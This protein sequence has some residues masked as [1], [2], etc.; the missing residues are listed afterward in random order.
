MGKRLCITII[1]IHEEQTVLVDTSVLVAVEFTN[2][3]AFQYTEGL[4]RSSYTKSRS[5]IKVRSLVY[6][7]RELGQLG[8]AG[9]PV[10]T[11]GPLHSSLVQH[12]ELEGE[13]DTRILRC[14]YVHENLV[15]DEWRLR[16]SI[17]V[18]QVLRAAIEELEAT[19]QAVVHSY[20]VDTDI[21]GSRL[22]P[23]QVGVRI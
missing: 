19:T 17:S 18:K 21:E 7:V 14:T 11:G 9:T 20:E 4:R 8:C 13:L 15:I 3:T 16:S 5:K 10:Q 1:V 23:C 12:V 22:L 6:I 2:L